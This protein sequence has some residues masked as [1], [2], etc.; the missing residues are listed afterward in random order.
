MGTR[1]PLCP[2]SHSSINALGGGGTLL[3]LLVQHG[4][5]K[6]WNVIQSRGLGGSLS[7]KRNK[8]K[9]REQESGIFEKIIVTKVA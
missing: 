1:L 9:Q 7:R 4:I 8:N 2:A 3:S 6:L 5:D